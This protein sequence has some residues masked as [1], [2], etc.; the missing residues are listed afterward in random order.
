MKRIGASI[1]SAILWVTGLG[2]GVPALLCIIIMA[3]LL[4][5]R[6]YNN[7]GR[8]L[9]RLLVRAFGGRVTVE[10]VEHIDPART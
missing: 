3:V 8:A 10:G 6:I 4:P 1:L 9:L 2:V 5:H 7:A